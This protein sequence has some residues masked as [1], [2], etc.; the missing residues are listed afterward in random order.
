[1]AHCVNELQ[2]A[3]KKATK[4]GL[5]LGTKERGKVSRTSLRFTKVF[6]DKII[7]KQRN[8]EVVF[9][10]TVTKEDKERF[11]EYSADE[12]GVNGR[13]ELFQRVSVASD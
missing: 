1:M 8:L 5:M 6:T 7:E 10:H 11:V 13:H 9:L 12:L 2:A 3:M 4:N